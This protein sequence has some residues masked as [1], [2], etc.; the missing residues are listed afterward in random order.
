M[1]NKGVE[2]LK[3]ALSLLAYSSVIWLPAI[4]LYLGVWLWLYH[5]R[6]RWLKNLKWSL[7]EIKLPKE[8]AKT[9][10]AMEV[11]L[12]A[13][14]IPVDATGFIKSWFVGELRFYSSLELVSLGGEIHFYVRVPAEIKNR[15]ESAI[16]SQYPN[17]EIYEAADYTNN[18]PY[19]L[20]GANWKLMGTELQLL[21][22]D[23]YPIKT[24][25]DYGTDKPTSPE[26]ES[27]KVDP[28]TPMIEFFGTLKGE[29][30]IWLQILLIATRK[31]FTKKK[32]WAEIW[33]N[34]SEWFKKED[35]TVKAKEEIKKI[36]QGGETKKEKDKEG[37][38]KEPKLV[39][40]TPGETETLKAIERT[41]GK[42]A[43]D[44]GIRL[45][46][47]APEDKYNKTNFGSM[48]SC[49]TQFNS[50]SLNGFKPMHITGFTYPWQDPTGRRVARKKAIMLDAY[51][52]RSYFYPPYIRKQ[53]IFSTEEVATIYHFPG[54]VATTPSLPKIE[55]KRAEPPVNLP[56]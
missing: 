14:H 26:E 10:L 31:R 40:L 50:A 15:V 52:R 28:M 37:K 54:R 33:W 29:E 35:W 1:Y 23:A 8:I 47:L 48:I 20:P 2:D 56:V 17:V 18:V 5:V 11:M 49:L 27:S 19:G 4:L 12:M 16:Y 7:L 13:L 38:E 44:C 22:S 45:I 24:Y 41:L 42:P 43:F 34:P 55:S 25:I 51:R 21:K 36:R 30:Q 46:Y 9:P 6:A 39:F 3:Q 53:M 32:K